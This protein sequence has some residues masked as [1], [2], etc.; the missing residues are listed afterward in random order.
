M[1]TKVTS[2]SS[3]HSKRD[4]QSPSKLGD[5]I[6][7]VFFRLIDIGGV[8]Y[9]DQF[10]VNNSREVRGYLLIVNVI[11]QQFSFIFG[12]PQLLHRNP[13]LPVPA[14]ESPQR[15]QKFWKDECQK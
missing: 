13:S 14:K 9:I 10:Q 3:A 15:A 4:Q 8:L 6:G 11:L 7:S 5:D 12:M 2:V 1:S